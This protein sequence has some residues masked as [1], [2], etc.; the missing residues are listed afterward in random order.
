MPFELDAADNALGERE[1]LAGNIRA[2]RREYALHAGA[3][4]GRT[5]D[6]LHLAL[7]GVDDADFQPVGVGMLL[8]LDH[9]SDDEA[10]VFA[11]RVLDQL[12][13][14]ADAGQRIDDL[15]QRSRG[16]EVVE[17]PG[18]GEFHRIANWESGAAPCGRGLF[19]RM[20]PAGTAPAPS[21]VAIRL[22]ADAGCIL[23]EAAMSKGQL[24]IRETGPEPPK[25]EG[26]ARFST[27]TLRLPSRQATAALSSQPRGR[28][29]RP[30][31]APGQ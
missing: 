15:G 31:A 30:R 28:R 7:A 4:V 1:L 25:K 22:F 17:Q 19:P 6:D 2:Y 20:A 13:L 16:V 18:E 27:L 11:R 5:A 24:A 23:S 10:V 12:N 3:R 8:G 14:E 9:G 26:R 21:E 29:L